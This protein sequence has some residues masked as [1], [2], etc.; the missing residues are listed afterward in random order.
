MRRV[1]VV[2]VGHGIEPV[3]R[4]LVEGAGRARD[5]RGGEM[6]D[7]VARG[8][9]AQVLDRRLAVDA[10]Q[11]EP[12]QQARRPRFERRPR[13]ERGPG[14]IGVDEGFERPPQPLL[15]GRPHQALQQQVVQAECDIEGGIAVECALGVEHDRSSYAV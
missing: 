5:A 13:L 14:E 4:D 12:R 11:T 3:A 7:G 2:G 10:R 15:L 8:F 9:V 6:P 1:G